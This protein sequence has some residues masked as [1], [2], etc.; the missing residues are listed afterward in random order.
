ML[1]LEELRQER[2]V[3]RRIDWDLTPQAAFEAYQIKTAEGMKY[4]SLPETFYFTISHWP[5]RTTEVLLVKRSLKDS[6]EICR[7][8]VPEDL[9]LACLSDAGGAKAPGGQYAVDQAIKDWL[10]QALRG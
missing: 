5:G 8:P 2:D 6:E 4:R 9:V 1:S 10:A 3:I 7:L